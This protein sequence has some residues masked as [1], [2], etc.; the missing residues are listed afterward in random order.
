MTANDFWFLK[1]GD[2][3][4]AQGNGLAVVEAA[5]YHGECFKIDLRFQNGLEIGR[6]PE[7]E[8]ETVDLVLDKRTQQWYSSDRASAKAAK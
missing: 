5:Y 7:T 2:I 8:A 1:R 3:V 4:S 6:L